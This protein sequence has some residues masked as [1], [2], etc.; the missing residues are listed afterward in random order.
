[1]LK[2]ITNQGFSL[3]A[4]ALV[5]KQAERQYKNSLTRYLP[6]FHLK[7][8]QRPATPK[9]DTSQFPNLQIKIVVP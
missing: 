9:F 7:I 1:M 4:I 6:S 2:Y 5:A 8:V 3:K